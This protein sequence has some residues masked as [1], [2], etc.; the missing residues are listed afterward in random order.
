MHEDSVEATYGFPIIWKAVKQDFGKSSLS[1]EQ[2]TR[3]RATIL[4]AI[5]NKWVVS[6]MRKLDIDPITLFKDTANSLSLAHEL[7]RLKSKHIRYVD[8]KGKKTIGTVARKY[9]NNPL[10]NLLY[11]AHSTD[12]VAEYDNVAEVLDFIKV[13]VPFTDD[14]KGANPYITAWEELYEDDV[15]REFAVKLMFYSL[16]VSNDAGGNNLFKYVP[17]KM[18]KAYGLFDAER[19]M[20]ARLNDPVM[21]FGGYTY[22]KDGLKDIIDDVESILVEDFAFSDPYKLETREI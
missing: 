15:T 18:L 10:L 7:V 1:E 3:L 16:L 4:G 21:L 13:H 14:N 19:D 5:K 17:Y 12:E 6:A 8:E 11:D 2:Q 22:A 20:I 9:K